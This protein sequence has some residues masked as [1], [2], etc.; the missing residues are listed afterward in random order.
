MLWKPFLQTEISISMSTL[1][2]EYS[3]LSNAPKT[4]LP[5]KWIIIE[6]LDV[7]VY[8]VSSTSPTLQ[9]ILQPHYQKRTRSIVLQPRT[10]TRSRF[11]SALTITTVDS[12]NL[13]VAGILS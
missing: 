12:H 1:E 9:A 2:A 11:K 7:T 8:P 13:L 4:L 3:A 10:M 5:L 6:A